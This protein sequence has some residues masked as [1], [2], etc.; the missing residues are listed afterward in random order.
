MSKSKPADNFVVYAYSREVED[1]F[2]RLGTFYYIGKGKPERPYSYHR[3]IKRP[4]D[5]SKIHI[6]HSG[7]DESTAFDYE[8]KLIA[9][10]GRIE[11]YPEWGVL[12]NFTDG[13]EGVS[14]RIMPEEEKKRRSELRGDKHPMSG[15]KLSEEWC[16]NIGLSKTGS[17]NPNYGKPKPPEV[18]RKI[19]E[20]NKGKKRSPE[21][22]E[23]IRRGVRRGENHPFYGKPCSPERKLAIS[24]ANTGKKRSQDFKGKISGPGN[25]M[26]GRRG[27]LSAQSILRDWEHDEYGVVSQVCASELADMFPEQK[28]NASS[29]AEVGRGLMRYYKGWK[30][31]NPDKPFQSTL[32]Y[33]L[34]DWWHPEHGEQLGVSIPNMVKRY[35]DGGLHHSG[36]YQVIN[37]KRKH[38]KGWMLLKNKDKVELVLQGGEYV[39]PQTGRPKH[40]EEFK[41]K[42]AEKMSGKNNPMSGK[43]GENNP[44]FGRKR[45]QEEKD[46]MKGENNGMFGRTGGAS[47]SAKLRDWFHSEYGLVRQTCIT[48]MIRKFPDQNLKKDGLSSIAN[49]KAKYYKGWSIV[50][51]QGTTENTD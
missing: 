25:P 36:L 41:R 11:L 48:D 34:E 20:S 2:G 14:G 9:F 50:L 10:Y 51:E 7:L 31:I 16:R 44:N 40:T 35:K 26:Y 17:K 22:I 29:L 18:R 42:R 19:S 8:V 6:L 33:K 5:K 23:N 3:V 43:T 46:K 15:R 27:R 47:P 21:T 4:K 24:L 32:E 37:G 1:D 28:L 38:H 30:A 39:T 13:G 49:G 12:R 45:S